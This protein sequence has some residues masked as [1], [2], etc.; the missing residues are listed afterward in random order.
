MKVLDFFKPGITMIPFYGNSTSL[1]HDRWH[2]EMLRKHGFA[3]MYKCSRNKG[4]KL[5]LLKTEHRVLDL[6]TQDD[7]LRFCN[8]LADVSLQSEERI[9]FYRDGRTLACPQLS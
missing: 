8:R 5:E 7:W 2:G 4:I 9:K 1:W 3:N 6:I